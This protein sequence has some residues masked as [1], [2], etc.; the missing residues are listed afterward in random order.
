MHRALKRAKRK[1]GS[2][3]QRLLRASPEPGLEVRPAWAVAVQWARE[4]R[5]G[6][7]VAAAA[8]VLTVGLWRVEPQLLRGWAVEV[9]QPTPEEGG[10]DAGTAELADTAVTGREIVK[11]VGEP[12]LGGF[13]LEVPKNPRPGQLRPPCN[14][15]R[16]AINGGCWGQLIGE[17]PPCGD[18]AY[19]WGD[20][21]YWPVMP[22]SRSPTSDP[23]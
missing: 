5:R 14:P 3:A 4:R 7:L 15:P 12:K 2:Q 6:L 21:C 13:R 23:R 22:P 8:M 20:G 18:G 1:A 9:V 11:E 16:V 17:K 19:E 10:R